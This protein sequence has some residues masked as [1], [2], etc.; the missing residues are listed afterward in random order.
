MI[1]I[2]IVTGTWGD[3]DE[4]VAI[5]MTRDNIFA[6]DGMSDSDIVEFGKAHGK[7]IGQ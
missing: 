1:Y 6:L 7:P 5:P 3:T 4:L 2:D